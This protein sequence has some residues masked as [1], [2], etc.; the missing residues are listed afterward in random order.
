MLGVP[1]LSDNKIW[2]VILV[3]SRFNRKEFSEENLVFLDFFSNLVSLALEKIIRI[4]QIETE[5]E[6]LRNQLQ[7]VKRIP[8]LIGESHAMQNLCYY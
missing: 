3:D 2:G 7:S 5:N 1:I 4:E 8:E 6:I